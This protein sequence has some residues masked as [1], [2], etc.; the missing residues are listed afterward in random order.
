MQAPLSKLLPLSQL[1]FSVKTSS[2]NPWLIG[3]DGGSSIHR[4]CSDLK[5]IHSFSI[6][7]QPQWPPVSPVIG[8]GPSLDP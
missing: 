3:A 7:V 6:V 2:Y 4:S 5:I 8:D 1:I